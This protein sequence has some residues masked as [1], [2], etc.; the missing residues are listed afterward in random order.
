MPF[1]GEEESRNTVVLVLLLRQWN[2][3]DNMWNTLHFFCKDLQLCC[4]R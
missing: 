2:C 1:R 3:C 4:S